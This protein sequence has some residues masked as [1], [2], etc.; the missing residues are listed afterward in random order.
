M[1]TSAASGPVPRRTGGPRSP[2]L[3]RVASDERLVQHVREGS[4]A[5]FE[6]VYDRHHRGIL[7]FCRHMLGSVEEA[8]DAVQ[9][10]F[11]AAYRDLVGSEKDIQLRPWL[12]AIARNRCYSV[13]RTRRERPLGELDEPATENL[14]T[15]V[16]RRQDLRDLLADVAELPEDQR[17][18]LVLAELGAV[19]HDEIATVLDVPREKVKALVFQARTSLAASRTARDTPCEE[20]REQL[21]NLRGGSL[22]RTTIRRHLRTCAGCRA[23]RD[24]VA[25]QRKA[26]AVALPV[27]PTLGLKESALAAAFGTGGGSGAAAAAAGAGAGAGA[28]AAASGGGALAA[29]ALVAV[30]L[31]GGGATAGV[32]AV[33]HDSKR[34]NPAPAS[35]AEPGT[36]SH[37]GTGAGPAAVTTGGSSK[38][39]GASASGDDRSQGNTARGRKTRTRTRTRRHHRRAVRAHGRQGAPGQQ[40]SARLKKAKKTR[41]QQGGTGATK[42]PPGT[43]G[44]ANGRTK[45]KLQGRSRTAPATPS[46]VTQKQVQ[47]VKPVK[48]APTVAAPTPAPTAALVPTAEPDL[49]GARGGGKNAR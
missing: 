16:Q 40:K 5:A 25:M 7:A 6:A 27:V 41:P 8:E 43:R 15:E 31:V 19:S 13:L 45:P 33:S 9:H 24:E 37:G 4:E 35:T 46:P 22:R 21:A 30:V 32:S 17:A 36:P 49:S 38:S 28:A 23:F 29:K 48:P 2:V 20:I 10:T 34:S 11:I 1:E 3:L 39:G 14:S 18:A 42:A 47:K 44:N 26:L 12:Y